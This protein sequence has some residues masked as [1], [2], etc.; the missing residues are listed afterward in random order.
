[1]M[2]QEVYLVEVTLQ[3]GNVKEDTLVLSWLVG[4][5]EGEIRKHGDRCHVIEYQ[6]YRTEVAEVGRLVRRLAV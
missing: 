5:A 2:D 1:M 4:A 6:Y 3:V